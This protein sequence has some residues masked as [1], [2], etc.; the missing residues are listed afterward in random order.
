MTTARVTDEPD[1]RTGDQ[2]G[3][4][5]IAAGLASRLARAD[6]PRGDLA[7]LRRM[8]P[9]TPAAVF[10]RLA[11]QHDLLG[12]PVVERK[13][14]LILNGIALMTPTAGPGSVRTAHNPQRAVGTALFLGGESAAR[15]TGF[16]SEARLQRLLTARGAVLHT[17]LAR[18]FRMLAGAG[19]AF[20]WREMAWFILNDGFSAERA[21]E[22]RR[23]IARAYYQAE[24]QHA[25]SPDDE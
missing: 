6:F 21:E 7:A 9:D 2:A 23:R 1:L 10:W 20:D 3:W 17:L 16:Y 25:P 14:M 12:A 15:T 11:A 13:W 18:M 22:S 8:N 19:A 5:G 24:R 4:G